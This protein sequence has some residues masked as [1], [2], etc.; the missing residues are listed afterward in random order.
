MVHNHFQPDFSEGFC[1]GKGHETFHRIELDTFDD[2]RQ[3]AGHLLSGLVQMF[4]PGGVNL[5]ISSPFFFF[6]KMHA[7]CHSF[8]AR[9]LHALMERTVCF[10]REAISLSKEA[11]RK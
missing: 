4:L 9:R 3:R 10:E 6:V 8:G 7:A 2:L 1:S 5:I 11:F